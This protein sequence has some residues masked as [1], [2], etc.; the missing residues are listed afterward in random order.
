MI[1]TLLPPPK[2]IVHPLLLAVAVWAGVGLLYSLHFS[3][4]LVYGNPELLYTLSLILLPYVVISAIF[5]AGRLCLGGTGKPPRGDSEA[6]IAQFETRLSVAFRVWAVLALLETIATGGLPLFWIFLAPSK[7]YSDYGIPSIHGFVNS[8]LLAVATAY[9]ALYLQKAERRH[10]KYSLFAIGWSILIISRGMA[11]MLL[12]QYAILFLRLRRVGVVTLGKLG[13]GLLAFLFLFGV[14][15]DLRQ[16]NTGEIFTDLARPSANYPDWMPTTVLWAYIYISTPLN[17]LIY[18]M[19]SVKPHDN[20][21]FPDTASELFPT[22]IRNVIYGGKTAEASQGRLV[23]QTFNASTAFVGPWQ[24]FGSFGIILLSS[25]SAAL[26]RYF[27]AKRNFQG[28]LIFVVMTQCLILTL[29]FNNYLALPVLF[30][31][32]WFILFLMPKLSLTRAPVL[33]RLSL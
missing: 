10:L 1:R 30:Q 12:L 20:W 26:G 31:N 32:I 22:V 17:N 5:F 3:L 14:V 13:A 9:F 28:V 7:A 33:V 16:S 21:L 15:G 25:I 18:N 19:E 27:W 6:R 8:M 24:D 23:V 4:L 2:L 29:F 11:L